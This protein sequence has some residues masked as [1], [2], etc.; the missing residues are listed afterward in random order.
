MKSQDEFLMICRWEGWSFLCL[1]FIAMPLK[2]VAGMPIFV[3]YVGAIHGILAIAYV[4]FAIRAA[5][6]QNWSLKD[7]IFVLIASVVP[8]GTFQIEKY[9]LKKY[10]QST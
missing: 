4:V 8:F 1:L 5:R 3:R 10:S 7:F 6:S 9:L 2:Y